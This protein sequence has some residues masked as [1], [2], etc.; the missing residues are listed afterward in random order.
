MLLTGLG[1]LVALLTA[2]GVVLARRPVHGAVALLGHSVALSGLYL[3]LAAELV[4]VGQILI[5]S[6]AIVV[7]FLFVVALLP[8]GGSEGPADL[9]RI[10]A[11]LVGGAAILGALAVTV[12]TVTAQ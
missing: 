7:L 2:L 1:C 5:Y 8:S 4:A 10:T 9:G 3:L 6:G 11:A 12:G